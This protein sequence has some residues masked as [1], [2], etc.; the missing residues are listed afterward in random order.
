MSFLCD[1]FLKS[2]WITPDVFR[3]DFRKPLW[4][5][6]NVSQEA[7]YHDLRVYVNY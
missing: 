5:V 7:I 1:F 6:I 4:L 3:G 2:P